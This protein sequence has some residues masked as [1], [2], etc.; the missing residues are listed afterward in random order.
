MDGLISA[1]ATKK[2]HFRTAAA[3]FSLRLNLT[4]CWEGEGGHH[5]YLSI[6][7]CQLRAI[8]CPVS[9]PASVCSSGA[10][11]EKSYTLSGPLTLM[12]VLL[13]GRRGNA[14]SISPP[15]F[16]GKGTSDQLTVPRL[17][18]LAVPSEEERPGE[19]LRAHAQEGC[20]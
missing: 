16:A 1:K 18:P 11:T 15:L 5:L 20:R 2:S 9:I 19:G 3:P 10:I 7:P 12:P 14:L 6:S 8:T 13:T 4:S 17:Q